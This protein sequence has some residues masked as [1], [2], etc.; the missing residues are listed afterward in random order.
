MAT[1]APQQRLKIGARIRSARERKGL[2][3]SRLAKLLAINQS[4]VSQWERG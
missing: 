1:S 4:V 3:Q 2:T